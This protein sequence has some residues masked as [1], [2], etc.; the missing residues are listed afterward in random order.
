MTRRLVAIGGIVLV[1]LFLAVI[2]RG[3]VNSSRANAV[4]DYNT[5]VNKLGTASTSNVAQALETLVNGKNVEA[6]TQEQSLNDLASDSKNLTQQARDLSTP[7]GLEPATYN[8][9]TALSLRA[10]ALGRIAD[11]IGKARGTSASEQETATAEIAGEMTAL[12]AS[13]VLWRA[14][15]TPFMVDKFK[16]IDRSSDDVAPSVVL[17]D[18]TWIT[19]ATVANR[20]GGL[21]AADAG[22][23]PTA[24]IAPGTHGHGLASVSVN[25]KELAAGGVTNVPNA[26]GTSFTVTIENQ[27]ENDE[28]NVTVTV[29]GTAQATGKRVFNQSKKQPSSLKGTKTPVTIPIPT[30]VTGSVKVVVE[31]KKVPG[32]SN[33]TNNKQTYNVIF[34]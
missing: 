23:D 6:L 33:T 3:C 1:F 18:Q 16:D 25:G 20:I 30:A 19:P 26:S 8:L 17:K 5:E 32:E 12:L 2:M 29:T 7:G 14:R 21:V 11:L 9:A 13:D 24:E 10:T 4:K 27:G 28:Q 31:V 34:N 15:V 22:D